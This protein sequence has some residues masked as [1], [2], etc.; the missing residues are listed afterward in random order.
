M[1]IIFCLANMT[2]AQD[3]LKGSGNTLERKK[4]KKN[5]VRPHVTCNNA[6]KIGLYVRIN[7]ITNFVN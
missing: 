4:K 7:L 1:C 3:G 6:C 2:D 5:P